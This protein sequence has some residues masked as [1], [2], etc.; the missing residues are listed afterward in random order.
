MTP[1]LFTALMS[2][3]ISDSHHLTG[4]TS[5]PEVVASAKLALEQF[6]AG[7]TSSPLLGGNSSLHRELE[8]ELAMFLN[9][10]ACLLYP[11]CFAANMGLFDTILG[12]EDAI[13]SDQLNHGSLIDGIR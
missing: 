3:D 5:H 6:G 9:K 12:S 4:L 10:E 7:S 11:S 13:F 1:K 2:D 8:E